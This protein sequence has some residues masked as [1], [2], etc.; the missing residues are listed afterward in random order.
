[1][2]PGKKKRRRRKANIRKNYNQTEVGIVPGI[3]DN[4]ATIMVLEAIEV[5]ILP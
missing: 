5:Q 3:T 1:M 4:V 2:P